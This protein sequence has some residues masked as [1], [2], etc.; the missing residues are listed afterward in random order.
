PIGP[1]AQAI[2]SEYIRL[3]CPTCGVEGRPPRL[4]CRGALCGPCADRMEER[5][6]QGPWLL[7]EVQPEDAYLFSP[8]LARQERYEDL[9]AARKS[10]V[11]PSQ[12]CRKKRKPRSQ[13]GQRYRVTSYNHAVSRV[14]EEHGL[15][16]WHV[17]QLR[18][19]H[20]T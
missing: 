15:E 2:L 4:A 3:R 13:P 12:V 6:I 14:C 7:V 19:S 20:G 1:K 9:R 18:H 16:V 8:A 5:G 11:Q 17:N 10:K